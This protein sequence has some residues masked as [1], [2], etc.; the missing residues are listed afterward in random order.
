M[1][2]VMRADEDG[3]AA[4]APRSEQAQSLERG[5]AVIRAFGK[6]RTRMTI[7][8]TA[9]AVGI[10][11]GTA[12]RFLLTL[13]HLGYVESDGRYF[14]LR[15]R[16]LELGY[17]TLAGQSWW[18]DGQRISQRVATSLQMPCAIGVLDGLAAV[19]VCY[20]STGQ[21]VLF[22]RAVGT[23]LPAYAT[24]IG[25]SLL[26]GLNVDVLHAQLATADLQPLTQFTRRSPTELAV[27]IGLV[28]ERGY[29]YVDQELEIGLASLGVPILDR[30]GAT[31]AAISV[32]FRPDAIDETV[33]A[34]SAML[35][36]LDVAATAV[37]SILP[38]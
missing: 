31:V 7:A 20:A 30:D 10:P 6:G 11:R 35:R 17:R 18:P 16:V 13:Q 4:N 12:Q 27:E 19:Y 33:I 29:A 32:S 34:G 25:R 2:T 24:A 36:Q 15:P 21:S 3:G 22:K 5:L 9:R 14:S 28:G 37:T 26:A 23:R 8:D 1:E 38:A